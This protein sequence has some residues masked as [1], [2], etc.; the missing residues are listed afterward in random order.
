MKKKKRVPLQGHFGGMHRQ[1]KKY[2]VAEVLQ[3]VIAETDKKSG[4]RVNFGDD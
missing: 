2:T 4:P 1:L 3:H